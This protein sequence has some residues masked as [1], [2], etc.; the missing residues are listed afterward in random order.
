MYVAVANHPDIGRYDVSS[1][2]ACISGAAALAPEV[3]QSFE[4]L[5][6]AVVEDQ[7]GEATPSAIRSTAAQREAGSDVPDTVPPSW[8]WRR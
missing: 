4:R 2:R 7:P 5:T 1:I 6:G 3:Q 8:T